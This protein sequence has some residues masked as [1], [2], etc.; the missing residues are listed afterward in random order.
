ML[1][2][3][4]EITVKAENEMAVRSAIEE[5]GYWLKTDAK[6]SFGLCALSAVS[7]QEIKHAQ[8]KSIPLTAQWK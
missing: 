6:I 5:I 3:I 2:T 8:L 1:H 7:Q 4:K